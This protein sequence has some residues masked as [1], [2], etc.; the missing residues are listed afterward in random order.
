MPPTTEPAELLSLL[1]DA[2]RELGASVEE[3]PSVLTGAVLNSEMLAGVDQA[4]TQVRTSRDLPTDITGVFLDRVPV[5]IGGFGSLDESDAASDTLRRYRNQAAIARSWLGIEAQNLQFFIFGPLG[6]AI[7]DR[8]LDLAE[9]IEADDRVCRKIVWLPAADSPQVSAL[10]F[11]RRTFLARP[12][13]G[14]VENTVPRLDQ[15]SALSL[16]PGWR[17]VLED[18][19]LDPDS[20]V[21]KIVEIDR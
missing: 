19:T 15:M 21:A 6:S 17:E 9:M 14:G 10:N 12:W 7:D 4:V 16:P 2:A 11:L 20:L 3:A 1:L 13:A 18:E 5:L 8:W